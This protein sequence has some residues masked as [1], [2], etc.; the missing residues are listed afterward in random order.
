MTTRIPPEISPQLSSVQS[1]LSQQL[2]GSLQGIHLFGSAVDGGLHPHSDVD[3]LAGLA[4]PLGEATRHA[5]MQKLLSISAPP[6]KPLPYRPLEVTFVVLGDVVPWRYP[7]RRELQFGEWLRE[8]LQAGHVEPA[9]LDPDLAILLTK[10][11]QH[12]IALLGPPASDLYPTVPRQDLQRALADTVAQWNQPSDWHG[13]ERNIVLALARI[14]YTATTGEIAPKDAA[15]D[16]AL[17][18]LPALHRAVLSAAREA[19]LGLADDTLRHHP[20]AVEAFVRD[21]RGWIE[22]TVHRRV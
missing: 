13:D 14:W 15:A 7:A 5:L 19:Y 1:L 2:P 3:L 9:C 12:S 20:A 18:R 6:G 16:W 21:V 11:R 17:E 10:V 4:T 8:E 22:A